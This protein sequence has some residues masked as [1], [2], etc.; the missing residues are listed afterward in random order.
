LDMC[1]SAKPSFENV[2]NNLRLFS[3]DVD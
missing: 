1:Y 3:V 2:L